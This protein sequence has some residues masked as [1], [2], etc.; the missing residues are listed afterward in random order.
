MIR[1]G[2]KSHL[3][4]LGNRTIERSAKTPMNSTALRF[5]ELVQQADAWLVH[6]LESSSFT[7]QLITTPS[8]RVISEFLLVGFIFLLAYEVAY[9][10]GIYLGLWEY[11]AKDIFTEVPIH[12]AHVYIRLNVVAQKEVEKLRE[13]QQLQKESFFNVWSQK[14]ARDIKRDIFKLPSSVQYHFE[15]SPEDYDSDLN[16]G[17]GSK[18]GHLRTKIVGLFLKSDFYRPFHCKGLDE[19]NIVVFN[20]LRNEVKGDDDNSYLVKVHIQTGDVIDVFVTIP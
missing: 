6:V 8:G 3:H 9:W 10:S 5:S 1:A 17:Y 13:Y 20:S 18:I 2:Q 7:G 19:K 4:R 16:P 15:F 11:H 14:K 12:C